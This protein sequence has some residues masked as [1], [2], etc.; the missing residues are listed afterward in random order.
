MLYAMKRTTVFLDERTE[1]DLRTIAARKGVALASVVREA[2][3]RYV[4]EE[5]AAGAALPSF[6]G[7]GA[8]GRRDTAERADEILLAELEANFRPA[9]RRRASPQRARRRKR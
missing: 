3:G 1:R 2:L 5:S 9:R 6:V 8:S 7:I 4:I